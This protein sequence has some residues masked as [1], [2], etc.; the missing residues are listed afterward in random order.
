MN[1]AQ[2]LERIDEHSPLPAEALVRLQNFT[3]QLNR[4]PPKTITENLD[5]KNIEHVPIGLIENQLRRI[6]FGLYSIEIVDYKLIVNEV[7]VHA[8]IKVFHPIIRQ[9][10]SYDGVGS[11]PVQQRSGS[12]VHEFVE[13]KL[14]NAIHRNL[15]AAYAFAVKNAA[16]KIG[17]IFGADLNRKHEDEYKPFNIQTEAQPL[18]Q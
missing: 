12:K 13:T 1:Q 4:K 2:A 5:G 9:W 16:K 14:V 7:C 17:K 6:Y 8:R 18:N 11:V 3:T 10:L 15:P